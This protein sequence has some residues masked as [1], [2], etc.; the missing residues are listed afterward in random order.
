MKPLPRVAVSF[1]GFIQKYVVAV[2]KS[3]GEINF[4]KLGKDFK[5]KR[6]RT[7]KNM[8]VKSIKINQNEV[9][10]K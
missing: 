1:F 2:D 8:F 4:L 3:T 10:S 6:K 7:S 9:I 5:I